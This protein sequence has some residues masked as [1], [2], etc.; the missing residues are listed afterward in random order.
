MIDDLD[1][2]RQGSV[3]EYSISN[4][5]LKLRILKCE[6]VCQG[7]IG[8]KTR[9]VLSVQKDYLNQ[10]ESDDIDID[11]DSMSFNTRI[12]TD[13]NNAIGRPNETD[14]LLPRILK[15]FTT[16]DS[17]VDPE[18]CV[19][20]SIETL[21]KFGISK[22]WNVCFNQEC[23]LQRPVYVCQSFEKLYLKLI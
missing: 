6:P 21:H 22:G 15:N 5:P 2:L 10:I 14:L 16:I 19:F 1:I 12:I 9:I 11:L 7:I 4:V 23:D 3:I 17:D 18:S 20:V 13:L 8:N